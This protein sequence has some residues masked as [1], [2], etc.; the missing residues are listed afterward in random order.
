MYNV[1]IKGLQGITKKKFSK[2]LP[3][4]SAELGDEFFWLFFAFSYIYVSLKAIL[5]ILYNYEKT[6][7]RSEQ[8]TGRVVCHLNPL[9]FEPN[10][11]T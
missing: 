5:L 3:P 10:T 11:V 2:N 7:L 9:T 6:L 8:Q 1:G 4:V